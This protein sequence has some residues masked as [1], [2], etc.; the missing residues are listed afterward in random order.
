MDKLTELKSKEYE[1]SKLLTSKKQNLI[2]FKSIKNFLLYFDQLENAT[3]K[4][5]IIS[6]IEQYFLQIE[7]NTFSYQIS[8][9]RQI[10]KEFI[11]PIAFYCIREFHFKF[12]INLKSSI[13]IG[14]NIDLVLWL[15]GV[16]KN[17]SYIP[18]CTIISFLYWAYVK[19]FFERKNKVY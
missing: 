16:L 15:L 14:L 12:Y 3:E 6:L 4:R 1:F 2:R 5:K 19:I 17:V 7:E 10:L 11:N 9:K 8:E 18:F 13:F